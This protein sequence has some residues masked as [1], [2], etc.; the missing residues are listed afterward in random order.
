MELGD[1]RGEGVL[2]VDYFAQGLDRRLTRQA[3]GYQPIQR[4]RVILTLET[5]GVLLGGAEIGIVQFAGKAAFLA[6]APEKLLGVQRV[7]TRFGP[8]P[9]AG[10]PIPLLIP[11]ATD[12]GLET[13]KGVPRLA[14]GT[15]EL[16]FA[17]DLQ[18]LFFVQCVHRILLAGFWTCQ[19]IEK[20]RQQRYPLFRCFRT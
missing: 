8:A 12:I 10:M 14:H 6:D 1:D 18:Q 11:G 4:R 3:A 7:E 13:E 9:G 2:G 16:V 20:R 15:G 19:K 5:L 17:A